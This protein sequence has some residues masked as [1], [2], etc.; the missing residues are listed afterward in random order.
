V[1][2]IEMKDNETSK[3]CKTEEARCNET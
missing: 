1:L 3:T 2:E